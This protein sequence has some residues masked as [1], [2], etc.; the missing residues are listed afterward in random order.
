[1]EIKRRG[2]Q[3]SGKGGTRQRRQR[4][5][6][7]RRPYR[8]AHLPARSDVGCRCWVRFDA[9]KVERTSDDLRDIEA[10]AS[11]S[12]CKRLGSPRRF[13]SC[14]TAERRSHQKRKLANSNTLSWAWKILWI[15]S[16]GDYA[17]YSC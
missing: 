6:R 11:R 5:V 16:I 1:M 14:R 12:R 13:R 4:N 9:A 7:A 15:R 3:P 8:L 10:A 17:A 2:S